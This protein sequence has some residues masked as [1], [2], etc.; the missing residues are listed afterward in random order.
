KSFETARRDGGGKDFAGHAH[1][2][3]TAANETA[4]AGLMPAAPQSDNADL[5]R[6]FR[7]GARD[8][9][10]TNQPH[11]VWMGEN[12]PFEQLRYQI[13]RAVDELLHLHAGEPPQLFALINGRISV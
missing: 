7:T 8:Q 13:F 4:Q 9:I 1:V 5:S 10:V 6:I 11:L 12:Q 2:E 3:H